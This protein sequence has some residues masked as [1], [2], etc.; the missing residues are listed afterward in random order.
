MPAAVSA[1]APKMVNSIAIL[2]AD[3]WIFIY[4]DYCIKYCNRNVKK[5][6]KKAQLHGLVK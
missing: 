3:S 2:E 6:N 1:N 4:I 5:A